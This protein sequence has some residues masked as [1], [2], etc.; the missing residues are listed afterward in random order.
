[1][2]GFSITQIIRS[3]IKVV[4]KEIFCNKKNYLLSDGLKMI[5][6]EKKT[7][8]RKIKL[9]RKSLYYKLSSDVICFSILNLKLP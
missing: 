2:K 6:L 8:L 3:T 9:L 1:M 7:T 5:K 4:S